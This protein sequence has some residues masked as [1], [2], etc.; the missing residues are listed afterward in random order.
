MTFRCAVGSCVCALSALSITLL[1]SAALSAQ[2]K[3]VSE[4]T[5]GDEIG[6]LRATPDAQRGAVTGQIALEIRA[7]PAGPKKL[8]LADGLSHLATEGDPGRDNVQAV[9]TTLEQ[10][11]TENPIPAKGDQPA[12]PYI[13]LARLVRYEGVT[14]ELSD[15]QFA[16]AVEALAANDA[17]IEKLDF[18]LGDLNG[19]KK[20]TL[21]QLHGNIVLVNF[22][23]TWC[24]PCRKELP[25]LDAINRHF[26][27]QGLVVL[28]IT[29]EDMFKVGSYWTGAQ[30]SFTVLLDPYHKVGKQFHVDG[31]PRT[32]V[33][34]RQGKLVAE[35]MDMRTQRQFL[36]M[37]AKAGLKPE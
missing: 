7:L 12:M 21:S 25:D 2:T 11:L 20:V 31:L 33:Y 29:D 3:P 5:I 13:D 16:K 32:F 26:Q 14:A 9:A 15:P 35:G 4:K 23:A 34:D 24:P 8:A 18:T 27:H 6:K 17:E 28:A 22:W 36:S 19:K 10:A 1:L 30:P 37:L